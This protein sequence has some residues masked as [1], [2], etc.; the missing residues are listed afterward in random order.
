MPDLAALLDE[1]E[2]PE[3]NRTIEV[4]QDSMGQLGF[5]KRYDMLGELWAAL[6][7]VLAAAR[8]SIELEAFLRTHGPDLMLYTKPQ[9]E[10]LKSPWEHDDL[11]RTTRDALGKVLASLPCPPASPSPPSSGSSASAP[12]ETATSRGSKE[13]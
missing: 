10:G 5:T 7:H 13:P 4:A 9:V 12:S 3:M 6:P 2:S 11:L 1:L 8:R